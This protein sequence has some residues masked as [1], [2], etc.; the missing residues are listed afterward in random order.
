MKKRAVFGSFLILHLLTAAVPIGEAQCR[1]LRIAA[2]SDLQF[3]MPQ[4]VAEFEKSAHDKLVDVSYGSSGNFFAQIRNG[5]PFELF[6]SADVDYAKKLADAKVADPGTLY[7]YASGRIVLWAPRDSKL[8]FDADPWQVLVNP[9]VQKIAVA[10]PEHAPYGRAA[11][12]ALKSASIYDQ[13]KNKLVF[14]EN[15]SQAAQFVQS[16]NAQVGVVALSLALSPAMADGKRWEIPEQMHPPI[17]QAVIRVSCRCD[18]ERANE[19]LRFIKSNQARELLER[20]GFRV[21]VKEQ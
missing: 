20:F 1:S 6:F 15:I 12:A 2:A 3:V 4:L 10:N 17:T 13:V 9:T 21:P 18:P 16:G 5:A 14:G 19:F 11:V 8:D 7:E